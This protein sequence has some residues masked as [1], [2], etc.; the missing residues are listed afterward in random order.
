MDIKFIR[1]FMIVFG[2]LS[3]IFDYL[4]FGAHF[5]RAGRYFSH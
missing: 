2:L 3:S 1:N 4:T 5:G